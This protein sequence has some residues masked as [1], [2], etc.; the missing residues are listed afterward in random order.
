MDLNLVTSEY[1]VQAIVAP[2]KYLNYNEN[3]ALLMHNQ[4]GRII[5]AKTLFSTAL[6]FRAGHG[7]KFHGPE[8]DI[9]IALY[10]AEEQNSFAKLKN[11]GTLVWLLTPGDT[12]F[13]HSFTAH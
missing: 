6:D 5:W 1:F 7:C 9:Y 3:P 2:A 8:N 12:D 10:S 13:V 4:Y 11:D